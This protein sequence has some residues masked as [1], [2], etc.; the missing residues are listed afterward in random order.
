LKQFNGRAS[1]AIIDGLYKYALSRRP[2]VDEQATAIELLH[3]PPTE[4]G[5]EDL[6]WAVMMLPEFQIIR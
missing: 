3:S 5:I 1:D 4:Q 2:T 6:L